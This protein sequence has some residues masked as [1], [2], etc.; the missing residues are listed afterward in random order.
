M[1]QEKWKVRGGQMKRWE[2]QNGESAS[3]TNDTYNE[4]LAR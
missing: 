2:Q 4:F 3:I 1:T